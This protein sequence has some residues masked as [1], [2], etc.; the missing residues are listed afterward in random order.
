LY[1]LKPGSISQ[2]VQIGS[3]DGHGGQVLDALFHDAASRG[4]IAVSGQ[5]QPNLASELSDR[6]CRFRWLSLGVL[7]HSRNTQIL[8]AIHRGDAFLSR[9]EGEWCLCFGQESAEWMERLPGRIHPDGDMR[10]DVMSLAQ[11]CPQPRL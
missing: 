11:A 1:Y 2:V 10:Q 3:A 6:H 9:L 4:A 5:L 8:Q 7:V